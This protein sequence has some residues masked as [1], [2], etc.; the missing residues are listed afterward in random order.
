MEVTVSILGIQIHSPGFREGGEG[1]EARG[2]C[3]C[4]EVCEE[5]LKGPFV[6]QASF[7]FDSPIP[8]ILHVT[9]K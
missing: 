5:K 2:G 8:L 1:E 4:K 3:F 6:L 7:R 9:R